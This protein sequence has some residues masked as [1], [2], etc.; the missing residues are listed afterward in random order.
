M[1]AYRRHLIPGA[2]WTLLA[3]L[4]LYIAID[5]ARA[6]P[7]VAYPCFSLIGILFAAAAMFDVH[8]RRRSRASQRQLA[9]LAC[10]TCGMVFGPSAAHEAFH[11]PRSP[12]GMIVDD[13]GY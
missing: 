3:S 11:P 13:F 4:A 9:G 8:L 12:H 2:I 5:F 10:P 7:R 1:S 6:L